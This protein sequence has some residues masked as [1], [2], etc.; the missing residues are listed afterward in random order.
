MR[1]EVGAL[2]GAALALTSLA[3]G[4]VEPTEAQLS[5]VDQA[6]RAMLIS[7][8]GDP[9]FADYTADDWDLFLNRAPEQIDSFGLILSPRHDEAVDNGG[10]LVLGVTPGSGAARL[11][12]RSGDRIAAINDQ[13]L[14]ALGADAEGRALA[15]D[16]F[17]GATRLLADGDPIRLELRRN[18]RAIVE[19]GGFQRLSLPGV[20]LNL[21][22]SVETLVDVSAQGWDGEPCATLRTRPQPPHEYD[23]F[24]AEIVRINDQQAGASLRETHFLVPGEYEIRLDEHIP[25][26][27]LRVDLQRFADRRRPQALTLELQD[28]MIYHLGARLLRERREQSRDEPYW[29]PVVWKLEPGRCRGKPVSR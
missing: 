18:G 11:G 16:R 2:V 26:H 24:P 17:T 28:G 19:E 15:Y 1:P 3:A 29:E 21:Q 8:S 9:L 13:P 14:T 20:T 7:L 4:S 25:G 27:L 22:G 5:R 6:V 23:L 12:I 10:L